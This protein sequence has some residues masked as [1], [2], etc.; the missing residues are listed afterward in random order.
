MGGSMR[1]RLLVV[2]AALVLIGA[3]PPNTVSVALNAEV[4]LHVADGSVEVLRSAR[5]ALA[6]FEL[7][8]TQVLW[9]AGGYSTT[10]HVAAPGS[11]GIPN[12][13]KIVPNEVRLKFMEYPTGQRLLAVEN[14]NDRTLVYKARLHS[15][16]NSNSTTVCMVAP[17]T[18][19]IEHWPWNVDW[20]ELRD[21][22]LI[23]LKRGEPIR[24]G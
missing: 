10:P 11:K 18:R 12:A 3:T 20:I 23:D 24:C 4:D 15:G 1:T 19:T 21:I 6:P 16:R 17:R 5:G 22:H 9:N 7:A 13:P 14:G 8:A 2:G